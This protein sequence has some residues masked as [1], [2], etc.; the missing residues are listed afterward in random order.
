MKRNGVT[1]VSRGNQ[2]I[3]RYNG[4]PKNDEIVSD[5][6]GKI[7]FFWVGEILKR[8]GKQWKVAVV[9]D[10]LDSL[11]SSRSVLIQRVFLTDNF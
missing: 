4:D 3:Y 7:A 8:N 1:G 11:R 2:T 9:R 5:K 6:A 10:D